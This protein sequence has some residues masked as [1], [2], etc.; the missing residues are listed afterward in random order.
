[1]TSQHGGYDDREFVAEY[2]DASYE[3]LRLQDVEFYVD[4]SKRTSGQTL[5]L[6]CGTGRVLIP[7]AKAGCEITGLDLSSHMLKICQEKLIAQPGEVRKRVRLIQGNMT[8]F[9][10]GEIYPLVTMPFRPFQ[11]LTTVEEQKDCLACVNKH[12]TPHGLLVFD[13]FHPYPPRLVYDPKYATEIEDLPETELPNGKKL[14]HTNRTAGFHRERQYNDIEL[15]YYISHPDG[16]KERLVQSFP[17]RYYYRY[18]VEH[19]L[20]LCGFKVVELFGDF[21]RSAFSSDSP[22]M[23]FVAEKK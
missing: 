14:R 20:E 22:E 2:Y 13:V 7:T 1:M 16:R 21:D 15:I 12:L 5:E 8:D 23:I 18:E 9:D 3:H 6:G 10:T 4:Y 11:L 17:M 19:L